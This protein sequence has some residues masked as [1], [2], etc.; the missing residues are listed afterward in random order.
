MKPN[1]CIVNS[2]PQSGIAYAGARGP[3][4]PHVGIATYIVCRLATTY[5]CTTYYTCCLAWRSSSG[6]TN[7]RSH[8]DLVALLHLI[9]EAVG[10]RRECPSIPELLNVGTSRYT[11]MARKPRDST[12]NNSHHFMYYALRFYSVMKP[13]TSG[14]SLWILTLA[15]DESCH[16]SP[17]VWY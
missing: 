6:R 14:M 5:V 4:Q 13:L 7:K 2:S 10:P 16:L 12:R 3:T 15:S 11:S 1:H 9:H 17:L 8:L